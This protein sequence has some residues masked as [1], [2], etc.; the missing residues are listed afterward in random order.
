MNQTVPLSV[1]VVEDEALIAMELQML[2]EDSG[3]TV[4]GWATD[5]AEAYTILDHAGAD[6]AFVDVHLADGPTGTRLA[7]DLRARDI[8]VVFMTANAKRVPEDFVG[9]IGIM[10]KPYSATSV[11]AALTYLHAGVRNPPPDYELPP[12]LQLSP[13]YTEQW[14]A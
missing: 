4:A 7:E 6:L 10:A 5:L 13:A 1:L 3:H 2:I 14:A 8:P 12:G 11:A 9:A